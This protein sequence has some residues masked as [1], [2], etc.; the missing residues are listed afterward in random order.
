M[1]ET[2]SFGTFEHAYALMD[3]VSAFMPPQGLLVIAAYLPAAWEVRLVD[4][5]MRRASEADFAWAT[6]KIMDVADHC[7]GGRVVSL[8]EGRTRLGTREAVAA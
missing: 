8:L 5:N 7:A 1:I 4:E 2:P 6:Q 3:G